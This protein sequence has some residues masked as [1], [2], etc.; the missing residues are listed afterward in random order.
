MLTNYAILLAVFFVLGVV[1][2]VALMTTSDDRSIPGWTGEPI[3]QLL[4]YGL[5][6]VFFIPLI[7]GIPPLLVGLFIWRLA[8]R[9]VGHPRL[10]VYA[11][12]AL[13]VAAAAVLV[14]RTNAVAIGFWAAAPAFAYATL[15]R[16]PPVGL[17]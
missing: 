1:Q 16:R 15:V 13:V 10:I 5:A 6:V 3:V 7:I 12:A 11:M 2:G 17:P 14:P 8:I 4:N 9:V